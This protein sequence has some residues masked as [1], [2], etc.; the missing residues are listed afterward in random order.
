MPASF[1][2]FKQ[3]C[4]PIYLVAIDTFGPM[5]NG[6]NGSVLRNHGIRI[7]LPFDFSV[8]V[9]AILM[10]QTLAS[11]FIEIQNCGAMMIVLSSP[12]HE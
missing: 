7:E 1:S 10:A 8:L 9:R 5:T 6:N 12:T 4:H 2:A 11:R 3:Y